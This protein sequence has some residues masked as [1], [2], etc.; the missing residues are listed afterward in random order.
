MLSVIS[1]SISANISH[2]PKRLKKSFSLYALASQ[3]SPSI[4]LILGAFIQSVNSWRF[5]LITL[6][7]INM[8]VFLLILLRMP[9][10]QELSNN[11]INYKTTLDNVFVLFQKS[12]VI[13]FSTDTVIPLQLNEVFCSSTK[14]SNFYSNAYAKSIGSISKYIFTELDIFIANLLLS[15]LT[16]ELISLRVFAVSN[17]LY[18]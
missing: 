3:L 15:Q 5:S 7:L 18:L 2:N 16:I 8:R 14:R 6:M 4:A 9:E 17:K 12:L 11:K 1:R 13:Y 10:T